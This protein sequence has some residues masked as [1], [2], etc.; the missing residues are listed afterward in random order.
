[1]RHETFVLYIDSVVQL[2]KAMDALDV[3]DVPRRGFYLLCA[4]E[5][6]TGD[7]RHYFN[8]RA[9]SRLLNRPE[10][11]ETEEEML[12]FFQTVLGRCGAVELVFTTY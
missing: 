3:W 6:I 1:M 8:P 4:G 5:R 11:C 10:H 9:G 2:R 7:K 12:H